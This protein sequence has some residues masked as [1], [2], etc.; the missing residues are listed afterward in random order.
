M[1]RSGMG[2]HQAMGKHD[3]N[4]GHVNV[5]TLIWDFEN[6]IIAIRFSTKDRSMH[7]NPFFKGMRISE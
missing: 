2:E 3:R 1:L 6:W 4:G 7:A 5:T